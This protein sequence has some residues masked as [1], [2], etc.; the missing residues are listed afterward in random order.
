[1]YKVRIMMF[2]LFL[3]IQKCHFEGDNCYALLRVNFLST[4]G[5]CKRTK[6]NFCLSYIHN[7]ALKQKK[8]KFG[9]LINESLVYV[10]L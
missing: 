5:I 9:I 2:C 3:N 6:K 4:S 10:C 1:M 8:T 7:A